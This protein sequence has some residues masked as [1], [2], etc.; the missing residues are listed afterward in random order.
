M[1]QP[2]SVSE[3]EEAPTITDMLMLIAEVKVA[4]RTL[5]ELVPNP[6]AVEGLSQ[7][8]RDALDTIAEGLAKRQSRS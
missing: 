4:V 8:V 3:D 2:R 6:Q 5:S 7:Y 1:Y